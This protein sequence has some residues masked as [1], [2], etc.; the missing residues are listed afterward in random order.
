[1][2]RLT[3]RGALGVV[4]LFL[5]W[6]LSAAPGALKITNDVPLTFGTLI[7]GSTAGTVTVSSSGT[8]TTTGGVIAFGAG[9]APASFTISLDKGK[10][11]YSIQL[12]SSLN[13]T[14]TGAPMPV[15][16]V[17]STPPSG[18][19]IRAKTGDEVMTVGATLHVAANQA[20]G[21]YSGT[22]NVTVTNE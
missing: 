9:A 20:A 21:S 4:L 7:A 6:T 12:Q 18:G 16:L 17:E 14:G 2:D 8:T 15:N 19:R 22:F 3:W 10:T 5:P 13:L 11:D 1:M